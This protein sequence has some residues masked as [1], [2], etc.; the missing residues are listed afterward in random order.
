MDFDEI[1]RRVMYDTFEDFMVYYKRLSDEEK[2]QVVFY[3]VV[4]WIHPPKNF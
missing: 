2:F 3:F 1:A 4:Q